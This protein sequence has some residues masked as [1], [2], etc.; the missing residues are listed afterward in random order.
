MSKIIADLQKLLV[1]RNDV[2]QGTVTGV[3]LD[4]VSLSSPSGPKT[5]KVANSGSYRLGDKVRFQGELFIGRVTDEL[6][7]PHYSV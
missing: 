6:N 5:F 4:S 3:G 7:I 1:P 2:L